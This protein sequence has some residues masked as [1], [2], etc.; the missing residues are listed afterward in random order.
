MRVQTFFSTTPISTSSPDTRAGHLHSGSSQNLFRQHGRTDAGADWTLAPESKTPLAWLKEVIEDA[1]EFRYDNCRTVG[2]VVRFKLALAR[3]VLDRPTDMCLNQVAAWNKYNDLV[4]YIEK[5][6][7]DG[8][9][10]EAISTHRVCLG[11]E[12]GGGSR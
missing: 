6:M 9:D 5:T 2:D 4:H 3:A 7:E 12:E 11:W 10:A 8:T 1:E